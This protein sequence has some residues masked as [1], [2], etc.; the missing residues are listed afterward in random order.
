MVQ[1]C[2]SEEGFEGVESSQRA[3]WG[4]IMELVPKVILTF[5]SYGAVAAKAAK[6][7]KARIRSRSSSRT[8]LPESGRPTN[9]LS[10]THPAVSDLRHSIFARN[11]L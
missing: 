3:E 4:R 9:E 2:D 7:G 1:E 10:E 6:L 5:A 11:T 8:S